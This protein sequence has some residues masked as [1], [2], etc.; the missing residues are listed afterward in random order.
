M[1][2]EKPTVDVEAWRKRLNAVSSAQSKYLWT[3]FAVGVFYWVA[4]PD[5]TQAPVT[6]PVLG[7]PLPT[8]AIWA[9]APAVLFFIQLVIFGTMRAVSRVDEVL[10]STGGVDESIDYH[11]NAIDWAVYTTDK[12]PKWV[13]K[14]AGLS[15]AAYLGVFAAEATYFLIRLAD[16]RTSVPRGRILLAIAALE[17]LILYPFLVVHI[18]GRLNRFRSKP[19]GSERHR[20]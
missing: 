1:N 15:Y 10:K 16:N 11:S 18:V 14:V 12:S 2:N 13:T 5:A 7:I 8:N 4:Q 19:W 17:A 3:L 9:T 6:I 20:I